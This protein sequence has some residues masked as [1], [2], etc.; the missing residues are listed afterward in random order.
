M[1]VGILCFCAFAIFALVG[2]FNE[3]DSGSSGEPV[4]LSVSDNRPAERDL[5]SKDGTEAAVRSVDIF[6]TANSLDLT[7]EVLDRNWGRMTG[8]ER[9][10]FLELLVRR[11]P[12]EALR[13]T[14]NHVI[15][16]RAYIERLAVELLASEDWDK[17]K[18][19]IDRKAAGGKDVF[20]LR[21]GLLDA[22]AKSDVSAAW[23]LWSST[24]EGR[25]RRSSLDHFVQSTWRGHELEFVDLASRESGDEL[26]EVFSPIVDHLVYDDPDLAVQLLGVLPSNGRSFG[27]SDLN[28]RAMDAYAKLDPHKALE[29]SLSDPDRFPILAVVHGA[30][31]DEL[32]S[33]VDAIL[34]S[35]PDTTELCDVANN[36]FLRTCE[37]D[38]GR[39]GA[40]WG[41]IARLSGGKTSVG[42]VDLALAMRKFP[43]EKLASALAGIG[44]KELAEEL[45]TMVRHANSSLN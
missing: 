10:Y 41:E 12:D 36:V 23:D 42:L 4:P 27:P 40:L 43:E 21:I 9:A 39:A 8:P 17:A 37:V 29:T 7:N 5:S 38:P 20:H 24:F 34:A 2:Y 1:K 44:D 19:W 22:L 14:D 15:P 11:H 45:E 33:L 3:S 26:A 35:G 30:P 16:Q 13:F 6:A 18:A 31:V 32:P 25:E 28:W